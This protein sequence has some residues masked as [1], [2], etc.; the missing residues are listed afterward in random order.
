MASPVSSCGTW[1][2]V[3]CAH[4]TLRQFP[5]AMQVLAQLRESAIG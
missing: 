4:A 3:A 5:E 2:D 1:L